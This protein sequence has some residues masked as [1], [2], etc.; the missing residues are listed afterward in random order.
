MPHKKTN[1][2]FENTGPFSSGELL[3]TLG[4]AVLGVLSAYGV[5]LLLLL[6]V[7]RL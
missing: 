7:E 6:P 1:A 5:V 2:N 4:V 3:Y